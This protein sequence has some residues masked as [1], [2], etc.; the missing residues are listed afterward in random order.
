MFNWNAFYT[1]PKY[2]TFYV[3]NCYNINLYKWHRN[4]Y[5]I[6]LYKLHINF[7]LMVFFYTSDTEILFSDLVTARYDLDTYKH[8]LNDFV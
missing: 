6:N 1:N 7:I 5:N 3:H 2:L 8:L 4:C